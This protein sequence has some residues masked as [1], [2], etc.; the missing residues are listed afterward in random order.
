MPPWVHG[1]QPWALTHGYSFPSPLLFSTSPGPS[2][3]SLM[4]LRFEPHGGK[5]PPLLIDAHETK[6][7]SLT[8]EAGVRLNMT[9][10]PCELE[11]VSGSTAH[12]SKFKL[13]VLTLS[14]ER[15]DRIYRMPTS[16]HFLMAGVRGAYLLRD[17][18]AADNAIRASTHAISHGQRTPDMLWQLQTLL[19]PLLIVLGVGLLLVVAAC[20]ACPA[21]LSPC[22]DG[23]ESQESQESQ[24]SAEGDESDQDVA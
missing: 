4:R 22:R 15:Q 5:C 3:C 18:S 6:R 20:A 12:G 7:V 9:S 13:N 17:F 16:Y 23:H 21:E 1:H 19:W 24:E 2:L 14:T 11:L 10:A 8:R